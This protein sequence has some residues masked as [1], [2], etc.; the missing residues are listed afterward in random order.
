MGLVYKSYINFTFVFKLSKIR[1][2][3]FLHIYVINYYS[4][5]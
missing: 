1:F 4:L 3:R 2:E 5:I